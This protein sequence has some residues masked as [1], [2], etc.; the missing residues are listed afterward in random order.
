[1]LRSFA[2][3]DVGRGRPIGVFENRIAFGEG[4]FSF[5]TGAAPARLLVATNAQENPKVVADVP[6]VVAFDDVAWSP[7]GRWIAATTYVNNAD[8]GH[9]KVLVVGVT[10]AG[11]V[12]APPRLVDTPMT[13]SA[14]GLRWLPDGSAVTVYGQGPPDMGFDVYLIPVHNSGRPV[15][16]TRDDPG[17]IGFNLLSPD[18]RYVAY[19]ARVERGTSLWL[20]ELGDALM[21]LRP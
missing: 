17:E 8:D 12:S 3:S 20:A 2:A 16:L 6:G 18:G 7:D 10:P 5:E 14:W 11:D 15:S 1:M 21:G 4:G 9:I 13:G 19:Q